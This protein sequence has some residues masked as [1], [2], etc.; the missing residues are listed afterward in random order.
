MGHR[1]QF[2]IICL[3][4]IFL[5]TS[6]FP[7]EQLPNKSFGSHFLSLVYGTMNYLIKSND[8]ANNESRE[9]SIISENEEPTELSIISE[10]IEPYQGF[11]TIDQKF[12]RSLKK[13]P[14]ISLI[15]R[16]GQRQCFNILSWC[17]WQE[18][19]PMTASLDVEGSFKKYASPSMLLQF[20]RE[21]MPKDFPLQPRVLRLNLF[22]E[23]LLMM[24]VQ[25]H[26]TKNKPITS[27]YL[28]TFNTAN[29][30]VA[31][32]TIVGFDKRNNQLL[33]LITTTSDTHL[34]VMSARDFL[35]AM[36]FEHY[37]LKHLESNTPSMEP[38]KNDT[39]AT[40]SEGG[41]P[42]FAPFTMITFENK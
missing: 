13:H 23:S 34:E 2:F 35:S 14:K 22:D 3:I 10:D 41:K 12:L 32:A 17:Y 18:K 39:N 1:P 9:L 36:K 38:T 7:M 24:L 26:I 19:M 20:I 16:S 28:T 31:L 11:A 29:I 6:G 21:R 27:Y 5:T 42:D 33:L 30:Q 4:N 37:L 15:W 8:E 25:A 40:S